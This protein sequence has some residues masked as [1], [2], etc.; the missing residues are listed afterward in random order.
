MHKILVDQHTPLLPPPP[1]SCAPIK[2]LS[3]CVCVAWFAMMGHQPRCKTMNGI[4]AWSC[5]LVINKCA[6]PP[7]PSS[8][9]VMCPHQTTLSVC[10]A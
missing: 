4:L 3:G 1:Q 9:S 8:P 2:Q 10:V 6:Q 7:S 5:P